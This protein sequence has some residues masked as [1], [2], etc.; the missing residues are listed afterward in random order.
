[1]TILNPRWTINEVGCQW[2]R[3]PC[4]INYIISC[5]DVS[6]WKQL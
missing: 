6:L 5:D 4:F 3:K 1:M 2:K